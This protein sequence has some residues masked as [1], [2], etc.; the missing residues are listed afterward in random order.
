MIR[1]KNVS[2]F[3]IERLVTKS[4]ITVKDLCIEECLRC[5]YIVQ[6]FLKPPVAGDELKWKESKSNHIYL[7]NSINKVSTISIQC[8]FLQRHDNVNICNSKLYMKAG[9]NIL[10]EWN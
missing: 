5:G 8:A 9:R 3:A 4:Y 7:L 6:Y 1:E 10:S 2:E